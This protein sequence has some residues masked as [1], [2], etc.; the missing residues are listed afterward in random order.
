MTRR[1]LRSLPWWVNTAWMWQCRRE[2]EAFRAATGMVRDT[3]E[4]LLRATL[5]DN[6]QSRFGR[7]HAFASMHAIDD[8]RSAVPIASYD[9]VA[10]R[11]DRIA[12]GE[13][14]VLTTERV[15]MFEPTGGSTRGSKLIPYTAT[16]RRQFQRAIAAW[17][18]D[19]LRQHPA[20]RAGTAYW[21]ISPAAQ[22]VERQ[23]VGGTPI[24]FDSDREYLD[25]LQR[26]AM[27]RVLVVPPEVSQLSSIDNF[28]YATLGYLLAAEDLVLI[29]IWSPTF[30]TA[31]LDALPAWEERLCRDL[32][33]GTFRLPSPDQEPVAPRLTLPRLRRRS[34][35]LASVFGAE[36]GAPTTLSSVW[37]R[38]ALISCWAD[39]AAEMYVPQLQSRFPGVSLQPKG[40]LA[41][42]GVVSIPVV[43]QVGAALAIRSHVF[44]FI[45]VRDIDDEASTRSRTLLAHELEVKRRYRVLLT[46]GGGLYRYDLG[47]VVEVVGFLRECPLLKF[48]G[49]HGSGSDLVGEKLN[50]RHVRE[51]LRVTFE[52]LGVRPDFSLVVPQAAPPAYVALVVC[53]RPLDTAA[54]TPEFAWRLECRLRS[55]PQYRYAVDLGQLKPVEI[56]WLQLPQGQAWQ[57]YEARCRELGQKA[58]DIKPTALDGRLD[59]VDV[60]RRVGGG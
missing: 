9:T 32:H 21:S 26:W 53:P 57:I 33:D 56:R 4:Q 60:F 24:G 20:V 2:A 40:L 49:R 52:E 25:G 11:I 48:H 23:T 22:R 13:Q 16:L 30:L 7:E 43:G 6:A 55:N 58:G 34:R 46:T 50:E 29:S 8:F 28:R 38:L 12:G 27:S 41:T 1:E 35:E 51:C 54:I 37:P 19:V 39:A 18:W 42:E 44:E 36:A 47:D 10:P 59:W 14:Q 15:L 31:L 3:Q 45:E 17:L 5:R